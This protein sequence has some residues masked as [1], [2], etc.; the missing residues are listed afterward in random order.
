MWNSCLRIA[1]KLDI[2]A[3]GEL[4]VWDFDTYRLLDQGRNRIKRARHAVLETNGLSK[5][6]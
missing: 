5:L 1:G 2:Q 4:D 3:L 6:S